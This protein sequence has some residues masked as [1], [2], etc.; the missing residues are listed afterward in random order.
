M[1]VGPE[2]WARNWQN[3]HEISSECATVET[4]WKE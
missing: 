2:Y 1:K 3:I 4:T